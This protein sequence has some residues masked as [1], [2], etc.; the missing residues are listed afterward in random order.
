MAFSYTQ[1]PDGLY[2]IFQD[3]QR[4]ATGTEAVLKNYDFS[5][6]KPKP[7]IP[8]SSTD[9]LVSDNGTSRDDEAT[10]SA[11]LKNL[12]TRAPF[13]D[14][15][16]RAQEDALAKRRQETEKTINAQFD[17]TRGSLEDQQKRETG[18][19]SAGL[20][21]A[22]GY[23]GFSGSS[24]GVL[25][26]LGQSHRAEM[27]SL[28]AKRQQALN[29]A[30]VAY[31]DK[32][33]ALAKERVN[34]AKKYEQ[35]SYERQQAYFS[36]LKKVTDATRAAEE[37]Q[38]LNIDIY[39]ALAE[40]ATDELSVFQKLNGRA[41]PEKIRTFFDKIKPKTATTAV[42]KFSNDEVG[43]LI[44]AGLTP[45]EMQLFSDDL[46]KYG[47]AKAVEGLSGRQRAIVDEI[48]NGKPTSGVTNGLTISEAKSLGLPLSLIG[49]SEQ[50]FFAEL[51]SDTPPD[52]F[53][54]YI[55]SQ[56]RQNLLPDVVEELWQT[57][58]QNTINKFSG[59]DSFSDSSSQTSDT[60]D[61]DK[62]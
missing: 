47:Y 25:L 19:T 45:Q 41:S 52:W 28:E 34:E 39:N 15:Y 59:G 53:I 3:G 26:N 40:G 22:G 6:P 56:K 50:E 23:L 10:L 1:K 5:T 24:Q 38:S 44:G 55:E 9:G 51:T 7:E 36:E 12:A 62:I 54:E 8:K 58:R 13:D 16:I 21:R 43:K 14:S 60:L 46:N 11:T 35:E 27:Q 33:F 42:Y 31:E 32:Q 57:F 37:E 30:R 18:S 61:Y 29:E 17:A 4:I 49:K 2:E 20:A 48:L